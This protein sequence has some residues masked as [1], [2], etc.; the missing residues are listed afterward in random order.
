[1]Y[2]YI[3]IYIYIY[4]C[5]KSSIYLPCLPDFSP[6]ISAASSKASKSPPWLKGSSR[7]QTLATAQ[8]CGEVPKKNRALRGDTGTNHF[9][10]V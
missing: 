1:M 10:G 7:E 3:Y 2:I 5:I 9:A 4:M 6:S 8:K